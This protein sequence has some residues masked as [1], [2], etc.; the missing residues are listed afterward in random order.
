M[1][2]ID[3][4]GI[5]LG[6]VLDQLIDRKIVE[7]KARLQYGVKLLLPDFRHFAVNCR[8][9]NQLRYGREPTMIVIG[10]RLR[11]CVA[12]EIRD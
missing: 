2:E 7:C 8:Y 9:T 11:P 3:R 10:S 4:G 1:V 12:D 5:N 6:R